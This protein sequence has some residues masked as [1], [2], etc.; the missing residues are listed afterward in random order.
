MANDAVVDHW[1]VYIIRYTH[2]RLYTGVT[3]DVAR[4]F[5]EHQGKRSGAKALRGKGPLTLVY[6]EHGFS[7]QQAHRLEYAIKRWPKVMKEAL[8]ASQSPL[9][10]FMDEFVDDKSVFNITLL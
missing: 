10:D 8:V 1:S 4:R 3:T 9:A 6:V 7:K 5:S 2:H